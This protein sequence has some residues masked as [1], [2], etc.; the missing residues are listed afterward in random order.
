VQNH[1]AQFFCNVSG[2]QTHETLEYVRLL[3][4]LVRCTVCHVWCLTGDL[5]QAITK[6]KMPVWMRVRFAGRHFT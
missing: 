1:C 3:L 2:C 5:V 6:G 4:Y